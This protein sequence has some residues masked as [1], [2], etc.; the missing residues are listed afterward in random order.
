[1]STDLSAADLF[2]SGDAG[3]GVAAGLQVGPKIVEAE[4]AGAFLQEPIA[5]VMALA[6]VARRRGLDHRGAVRPVLLAAEGLLLGKDRFPHV[7]EPMGVAPAAIL[8]GRQR[9][10]EIPGGHHGVGGQCPWFKALACRHDP[11]E[12]LL[13]QILN[14]LPVTD[15]GSDDPPQQRS[16]LNDITML[17]L[18]RGLTCTQAHCSWRHSTTPRREAAAVEGHSASAETS[19]FPGIRVMEGPATSHYRRGFV[20]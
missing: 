1:M 2:A 8:A 12:G 15:P 10:D 4:H 9:P 7:D 14:N 17:E 5:A 6:V 16:Q 13:H 3:A 19:D 20:S 18:T 11:G